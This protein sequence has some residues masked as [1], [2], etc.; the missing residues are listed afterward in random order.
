VDLEKRPLLPG[1]FLLKTYVLAAAIIMLAPVSLCPAQ[2]KP[3]ERKL[4][5][6]KITFE[7]NRV[8]SQEQLRGQL[9]V[10]C[11]SGLVGSLVGCDIYEPAKLTTDLA[12][13][14]Q[15]LGDNGYLQPFIGKARIEYVN[16]QDEA[17]QTGNIPIRLYIPFGEGALYRLRHLSVTGAKLISND[18]AADSFKVKPGEV[19]R[20]YLIEEGVNRLRETYGR[21]GYLQFNPVLGF[22]LNPGPEGETLVDLTVTIDEGQRQYKL[23]GIDITGNT[24]IRRSTILR[25]IPLDPGD[26]FDYSRW[27]H[28]LD[29]LNRSGLFEPI[30]PTDAVLSFDQASGTASV[31]LHVTERKHQRVDLSGGGGSVGGITGGFDY[32]NIDVSGRADRLA[33]QTRYGTLEKTFTADY[34]IVF[35]TKL[36]LRTEVSGFYQ[37]FT[38]VNAENSSGTKEPL[39]LQKTFGTSLDLSVPLEHTH[40]ALA[41]PARVGFVYS[42]TSTNLS[43]IFGLPFSATSPG[44]TGRIDIGSIMPVLTYYTLDRSFDPRSGQ[45]LFTGA[46]IAGRGLGGDLNY[47]RPFLDYRIFAT[48]GHKPLPGPT[49]RQDDG[50]EPHVFGMRFRAAHIVGFGAPFNPQALSSIDGIPIYKRYFLGGPDQ[51]RGYALNSVSPLATVKQFLVVPGQPPVLES[52][53]IRPI[54]GDTEVIFNAEYRVPIKWRFSAAAFFDIGASFNLYHLPEQRFVSPTTIQ[55]EGTPAIVLTTVDPLGPGQGRLPIYRAS[56]GGE[57]RFQV[58]VLNVPLRL[59]LAYNPNAQR[60]VPPSALLVP[61]K[62]VAFIVSFGRTL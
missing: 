1:D 48:L 24:H 13:V 14:R 27:Q 5:I 42:F 3:D 51:V 28:G 37:D 20:N 59:I 62:R 41:S 6:T 44:G 55:P 58:P 33:I 2:K 34:A 38:F 17:R 46:E 25:M 61:E 10:V 18:Q 8:F 56:V 4:R 57:L 47:A 50:R 16:P 49:P 31:T 60:S 9:R 54:G 36:P 40:H 23:A 15:F 43:N 22:N 26:V 30:Q 52:T 35:P 7:G 21:A 53:D 32:N 12:R 19:L 11:E 29:Q 39:F 45:L